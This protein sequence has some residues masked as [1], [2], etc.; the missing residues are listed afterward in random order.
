MNVWKL[1]LYHENEKCDQQPADIR[2]KM[3][4]WSI[5]NNRIALGWGEV[6]NVPECDSPQECAEAIRCTPQFCGFPDHSIVHGGYSLYNF[7]HVMREGDSVIV[8]GRNSRREGIM[9]I[10]DENGSHGEYFREAKRQLPPV[11]NYQHQRRATRVGGHEEANRLW[12]PWKQAWKD[13][14][15]KL[16]GGS[17]EGPDG[18]C[19]LMRLI[20]SE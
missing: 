13:Q 14:E 6:S 7:C 2:D 1:I 5:A 4:R 3:L 20:R 19:T 17:I 15:W 12:L 8:V 18:Y 10:G 16:A 9:R 11:G